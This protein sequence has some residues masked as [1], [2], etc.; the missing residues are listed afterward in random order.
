MLKNIKGFNHVGFSYKASFQ[1]GGLS[2]SNALHDCFGLLFLNQ[3]FC[4]E[5]GC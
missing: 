1:S 5:G 4:V 2:S 3:Y